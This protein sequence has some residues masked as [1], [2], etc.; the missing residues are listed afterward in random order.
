[1]IRARGFTLIE[2][3]IALSIVAVLSTIALPMTELAV[4]R[5]KEQELRSALRSIRN[6]IDAY[7]QA[8][9]EGRITKIADSTGY[10]ETLGLL[11]NG[12]TDLK[13]PN[14]EK[15]YFMRRIP[16]DPFFRDAAVPA[17]DTWGKRAYASPPEDPRE[18][19]DVYDVYSLASGVGINGIPYR[20]W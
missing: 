2:L 8:V 10:P 19:N 13:N 1:M 14:G 3:L 20:E 6:G 11:V 15:I 18:G 17:A 4:Q 5:N 9:D 16:R 7:R 12:V